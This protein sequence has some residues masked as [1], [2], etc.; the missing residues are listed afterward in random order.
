MET[1][2]L[3]NRRICAGAALL[4]AV[5]L[6]GCGQRQ[7]TASSLPTSSALSSSVSSS[8]VSSQAA[9]SSPQAASAA[10]VDSF[11]S[12]AVQALCAQ[13]QAAYNARQYDSA[14][15][16][17]GQAIAA[18][19]NCYQAYN[20]KAAAYYYAN[21]NSVAQQAI[22]LI[23]KALAIEPNYAYGYFN[24]ALIYK[25]LKEYD[26]S[27]ADFQ[28]DIALKPADAWAY[29]GIA[30]I[31][32]DTSQNANAL[33]YLRKAVAID[34]SVKETAKEQSHWDNLR[35]DATFQSIVNG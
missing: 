31:Y 15:N 13:A 21:G 9:V 24:R 8:A 25:G 34:D 19:A 12:T 16:Y 18:D 23:G 35:D 30:T 2:F 29:Y 11:G 20:L 26:A 10:N 22:T 17:A 4:L 1:A 32:A 7:Q 14:I 3:P 28:K 33:D 5:M 6:G 27:I